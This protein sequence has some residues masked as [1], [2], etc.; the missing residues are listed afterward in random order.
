MKKLVIPLFVLA[1]ALVLAGCGQKAVPAS[2]D[3]SAPGP[4][5]TKKSTP[6]TKTTKPSTKTEEPA[7]A[8]K[9]I[10][11]SDLDALLSDVKKAD[12][13]I[14]SDMAELDAVQEEEMPSL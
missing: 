10:D 8:A 13:A 6:K 3:V 14:D 4:E 7:A 2:P 5:S 9:K 11:T 1:L 12:T